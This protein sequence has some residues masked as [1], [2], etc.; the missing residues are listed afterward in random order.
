MSVTERG[1][2]KGATATMDAGA[3]FDAE[4]IRDVRRRHARSTVN[5]WVMRI[6]AFG[7]FVGAWFAIPPLGIARKLFVS[8]PWS[9]AKQVWHLVNQSSTW[10][11]VWQTFSA[12]LLAVAIGSAAGI[13]CGVLSVRLPTLERALNPYVTLLNALPRPALAPL[14][15]LWFGLGIVAKVTV[16]VSIVFFILLLNTMAGLQTVDADIA[17]LTDSLGASKAQKFIHVEWPSALPSIV[18]GL[19]LGSVYAV[20]G[21][22]VSEIVAAYK[23]LGTMLVQATNG[24]DVT[25]TF[26][27]LIL[28]TGVASVLDLA[29]RQLERRVAVRTRRPRRAMR[30]AK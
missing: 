14:F 24:F 9:V 11:N 7:V 4:I 30:P 20:L 13:L 18:A 6:I 10:E 21:V 8:D 16:G 19:R 17:V 1:D 12:A 3:A 28:I 22:V 2:R 26:A 5:M 29:V 27:V 25:G 23:G 15:I